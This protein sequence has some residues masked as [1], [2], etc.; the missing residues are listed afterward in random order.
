MGIPN[1]AM[2]MLSL[3]IMEPVDAPVL[4]GDYETTL[5]HDNAGGC[6][7]R[8]QF[9]EMLQLFERRRAFGNGRGTGSAFHCFVR[10]SAACDAIA[11]PSADAICFWF[12]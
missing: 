6:E 3:D 10:L 2:A 5:H 7:A 1:P 12:L 4:P 11:P 8:Y 9:G